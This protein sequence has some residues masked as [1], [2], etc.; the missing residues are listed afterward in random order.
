MKKILTAAF[1]ASFSLVSQAN[2]MTVED[3]IKNVQDYAKSCVNSVSQATITKVEIISNKEARRR[4]HG[5]YSGKSNA[6][7]LVIN[8]QNHDNPHSYSMTEVQV[9][10]AT[11]KDFQKLV[12]TPTCIEVGDE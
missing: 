11:V 1:I 8:S 3:Q 10:S 5:Q 7:V 9:K 6:K 2:E 12:G 4:T